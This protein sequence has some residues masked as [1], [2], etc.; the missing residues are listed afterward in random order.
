MNYSTFVPDL[1]L[2]SIVDC[3]WIVEGTEIEWQKITPD[4]YTE[5]VLHFGDRY[6]VRHFGKADELQP[7]AIIAGQIDRPLWLRASA[8]SGVFGIKFRPTGIW[9]LFGI[10]MSEYTNQT[11]DLTRALG[12]VVGILTTDLHTAQNNNVRIKVVEDYLLRT[13][14]EN[15]V[16]E[17]EI[18]PVVDEIQKSKGQLSM[19]E[20]SEKYN[21]S[22]RKIERLFKQQVGISAK[23][24]S[25][26]IRFAHVYKMIQ[27]PE[28][29]KA[30]ATYLSGYF[31]QAHFNKEFKEFAG[32]SPEIY[33]QQ[34]HA[35]SRFFLNR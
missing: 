25:R 4:G 7:H 19:Q 14:H 10:D 23:L 6:W 22:P 18:D 24:Y 35:F 8:T 11:A 27:Q 28:L 15:N 31:D 29:S 5:I 26:I 30:E 21:L 1:K 2:Q 12:E 17:S 13:Q 34:N 3:Y 33:F 32:E 16:R 20:L 9:K